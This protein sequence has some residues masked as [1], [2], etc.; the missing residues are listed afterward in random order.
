MFAWFA[1]VCSG[2]GCCGTMVLLISMIQGI[3]VL[4]LCSSGLVDV[5]FII[6]NFCICYQ[7]GLGTF[8]FIK[9]S[10]AVS[11]FMN[12]LPLMSLVLVVYCYSAGKPATSI[13]PRSYFRSLSSYSRKALEECFRSPPI[14]LI[15]PTVLCDRDDEMFSPGSLNESIYLGTRSITILFTRPLLCIKPFWSLPTWV[16]GYLYL[17]MFIPGVGSIN[18]VLSA[19][20]FDDRSR[21]VGLSTTALLSYIILFITTKYFPLLILVAGP[22]ATYWIFA[23]NCSVVCLFISYF[24]PETK[25]KTFAEIQSEL[26]GKECKEEGNY[27]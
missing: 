6:P 8:F 17:F 20:L 26:G 2:S 3:L 22:A 21:G 16:W 12:F 24:V 4:T 11:G 5:L 25:G 23:V 10:G 14:A 19:E 9:G 15:W 27:L 7:I 13:N 1:I 18:W